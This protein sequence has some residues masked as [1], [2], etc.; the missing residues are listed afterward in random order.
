[1]N[2]TE[3]IDFVVTWVDDTD[4]EWQR[5]Y[6][7]YRGKNHPEDKARY[8]DWDIFR[9]WFRTVERYAPWVNKVYLVTNGTFPKWINS[10]NP[11]LV[12]VDH[13]DFI[14]EK[15]LPTFNTRTIELNLHRIKGLSEHFVYF[16][17]DMFLNAPVSPQ[18]YFRN[19]LPC[20]CNAEKPF[21]DPYYSPNERF[22]N[23]ISVYCNVA[24]L[25]YHFNRQEVISK[26]PWKWYGPHLWGKF[27]ISVILLFR[28]K[29]FC[30]F[31]LRHH[32]IPLLKSVFDEVWEKEERMMDISCSRFRENVSLTNYIIRY[33][34]FATNRFHPMRNKY[35]KYF[36]LGVH[37]IDE[38]AKELLQ[39]KSKSVCLNDTSSC[40]EMEFFQDKAILLNTFEKKFPNKSF[41]EE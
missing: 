9:Y 27:F 28:R 14:P 19:G 17:D 35:G 25:N 34:Q 7:Q 29:S 23:R 15:Y 36:G 18:Y 16:N 37:D 24:V 10:N 3:K 41:F 11:K 2:K 38:I 5:L 8:R 13:K 40:T 21:Q 4:P 31:Q 39:G 1:M 33:W 32:E 6:L 12:L 26:A 20:D 22:R 30:A